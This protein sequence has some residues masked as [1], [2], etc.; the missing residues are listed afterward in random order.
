[1]HSEEAFVAIHLELLDDTLA[2]IDM[3]NPVEEVFADGIVKTN[4]IY[5][6]TGRLHHVWLELIT[7]TLGLSAE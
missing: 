7:W 2:T 3:P 1:M 6:E 5:N 4:R